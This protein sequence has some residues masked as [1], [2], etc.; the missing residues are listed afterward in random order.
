MGNIISATAQAFPP[1]PRWSVDDMSDLSG[2]VC[3]VTGGNTGIGKETVKAL[4][5]HNAKVYLAARD[6]AKGREAIEDLKT[7]TGKEALF[8]KLDLADLRGVRTAAEEFLSKEQELHILF[9][10]AGVMMSPLSMLTKQGYGLQW[11]T[12]VLGHFH[13]QQ[14]L[15]PAL[16]HAS[17]PE[18]KS[19]IV[20]TSSSSSYFTNK[21][22]F[23]SFS[24]ENGG[25]KQRKTVGAGGLYH[26]SKFGN[27]V[28]AR[29]TARRYGD[30][31]VV[32][33]CNPGNLQT[34]LWQYFPTF[35]QT[36]LNKFALH[37][38]PLGALTQLWAGTAP[39]CEEYNG[40][41]LIPWA[42]VGSPNKY[43]Q[44]PELGK[45]VWEWME[46]A[47]KEF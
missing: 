35:L 41:F 2:K 4:L 24:N 11:G 12:N 28:V 40:K 15:L 9:E 6:E 10:N 43:T 13:F 37:P 22:N 29:E 8:L 3:L 36:F 47:C 27:V 23:G 16:L 26:Q 19:R 5:T 31:I 7:A 14:L 32:T 38:V 18:H 20:I 25:E 1:K 33:S 21:I 44:D 46:G 42:R 39:E 34:N 17:T 45:K 30:K